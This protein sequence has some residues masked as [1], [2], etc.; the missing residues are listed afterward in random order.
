MSSVANNVSDLIAAAAAVQPQTVSGYVNADG[1]GILDGPGPSGATDGSSSSGAGSS[2]AK[3]N[4]SGLGK[5]DFL[6]LLVTQLRYQDPLS[7]MDNTQFISQMAQFSSLESMNN[8]EKAVNNLND[9]FMSSV[10]AQNRSA[11]SMSDFAAISL[12][13]KTV[14]MQLKTVDWHAMAG[15][16]MRIPV[17]LGANAQG[18]VQIVDEGGTVVA[19][20]DAAGQNGTNAAI[21]SWDGKTDAGGIAQAGTYAV[22]IKGQENDESLYAFTTG[23]VDGVRLTSA[24]AVIKVNG[25]EVP[26]ANLLDVFAAT[27]SAASSEEASN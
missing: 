2:A 13:G 23:T 3:S 1:T 6:N 7:P 26:M 14:H 15:E 17:S 11:I 8:V 12:I 22:R 24:G 27:P 5:N 19:T 18:T 10:D 16:S 4:R 20:L 25:T 9:S 21:V